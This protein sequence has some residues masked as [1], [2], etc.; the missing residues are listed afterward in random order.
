[1]T[2]L[3]VSSRWKSTRFAGNGWT[4]LSRLVTVGGKDPPPSSAR[5]ACIG[6]H[7]PGELQLTVHDGRHAILL[8]FCLSYIMSRANADLWERCTVQ[9]HESKY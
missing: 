2:I 5:E 9:D 8:V 4:W 3:L 6:I 1:M 7:D